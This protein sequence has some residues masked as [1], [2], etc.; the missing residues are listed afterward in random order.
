[1]VGKTISSNLDL[2]NTCD[3]N[4]FSFEYYK[5][6]EEIYITKSDYENLNE[7][8]IENSTLPQTNIQDIKRILCSNTKITDNLNIKNTKNNK[9]ENIKFSDCTF[10]QHAGL[11]FDIKDEEKISN[12]KFEK[13][14]ALSKELII[15]GIKVKGNF[16]LDNIDANIKFKNL[17]LSQCKKISFKEID[18]IKDMF[19]NVNWGEITPSR[20]EGTAAIFRALKYQAEDSKNFIDAAKFYALEMSYKLKD[21]G[22]ERKKSDDAINFFIS[23]ELILMIYEFFSN[24]AT[25]WIKPLLYLVFSVLLYEIIFHAREVSIFMFLSLMVI[26]LY[27]PFWISKG[28]DDYYRYQILPIFKSI[29]LFVTFVAYIAIPQEK[30]VTNTPCMIPIEK[31]VTQKKNIEDRPKNIKYVCLAKTLNPF[32][33]LRGANN[34]TFFGLI[35]K[36]Y[37]LFLLYQIGLSIKRLVRSQ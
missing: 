13:I 26:L 27:L 6:K 23:Y 21:I 28:R 32:G 31:N 20:F 8:N 2:E 17:D 19:F 37:L 33:V 30:Y 12:I 11:N 15:S 24:F 9:M 5:D 10:C 16:E 7:I 1:M 3:S 4:R 34:F 22:I 18:D 29:L 25:N 36:L 14:K 35:F